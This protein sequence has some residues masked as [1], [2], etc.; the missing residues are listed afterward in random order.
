MCT[1]WLINNRKHCF[2]REECW[3][4]SGCDFRYG[5]VKFHSRYFKAGTHSHPVGWTFGSL[6]VLSQNKNSKPRIAWMWNAHFWDKRFS[7]RIKMFYHIW[8]RCWLRYGIRAEEAKDAGGMG[9]S[10]LSNK[11]RDQIEFE[12]MSVKMLFYLYTVVV[13]NDKQPF[14]SLFS[15]TAIKCDLKL[16]E[17]CLV[18]ICKY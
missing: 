5:L 2:S 14:C 13:L 4:D 3:N 17:T 6:V 11:K 1:K 18:P 7:S 15:L 12:R 9:N 10:E 16:G 8:V